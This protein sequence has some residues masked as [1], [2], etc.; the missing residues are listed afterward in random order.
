MRI[1]AGQAYIFIVPFLLLVLEHACGEQANNL[2][3]T[4]EMGKWGRNLLNKRIRRNAVV[5]SSFQNMVFFS[6][7]LLSKLQQRCNC[8]ITLCIFFTFVVLEYI[9]ELFL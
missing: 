4:E 2:G 8:K 6:V 5:S 7:L 3:I 1:H 9:V